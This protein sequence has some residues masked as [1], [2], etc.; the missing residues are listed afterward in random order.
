MTNMT[1]I[2][3]KINKKDF[4]FDVDHYGCTIYY[5]GYFLTAH[6]GYVREWYEKDPNKRYKSKLEHTNLAK[7]IIDLMLAGFMTKEEARIIQ[8]LQ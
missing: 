6:R 1:K 5:K 4:M 2:N 7:N 3:K 8:K